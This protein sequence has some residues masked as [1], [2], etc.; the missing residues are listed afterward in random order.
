MAQQTCLVALMQHLLAK[1]TSVWM[2][3][4]GLSRP[5]F[6]TDASGTTRHGCELASF[7]S[8]AFVARFAF[9]CKPQDLSDIVGLVS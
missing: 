2:E 6:T 5:Q 8:C 1:S 7:G 4:W 9:A 3:E